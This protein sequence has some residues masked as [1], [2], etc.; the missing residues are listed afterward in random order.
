[1]PD[2]FPD[3]TVAQLGEEIK[4]AI[5]HRGKSLRAMAAWLK[6]NLPEAES[7]DAPETSE[8]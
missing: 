3:R 4:N 6:E 8:A 5:S 7:G 1:M 2:V